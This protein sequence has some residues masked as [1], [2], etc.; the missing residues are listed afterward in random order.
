M[1]TR[2]GLILGIAASVAAVLTFIFTYVTPSPGQNPSPTS[3]TTTSG[4]SG[5]GNAYPPQA[6]E[7]WLNA[8]EQRNG[9]TVSFCQCELS[10]FEQHATYTVFEQEYGNGIPGVPPAQMAN[11]ANS[12]GSNL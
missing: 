5:T 3:A 8:C 11:A 7:D 12:C 4:G 10:Y 6:Q 2:I 1:L 9:T